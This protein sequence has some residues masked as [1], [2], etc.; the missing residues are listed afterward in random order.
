[1]AAIERELSA[2]SQGISGMK[3]FLD[4]A[5]RKYNSVENTNSRKNIQNRATGR[6]YE[7]SWRDINPLFSNSNYN[8]WNTKG[9]YKLNSISPQQSASET[10]LTSSFWGALSASI[11][12]GNYAK[13]TDKSAISDSLNDLSEF[14]EDNS[15]A[16]PKQEKKPKKQINADEQWYKQTG[17]IAE[18]KAE[19]KVEGSVVNAKASGSTKY[20]QGEV[21]AK[22]VTGEAHASASA[23]LYVYEKGMDGE[24]KKILSPSVMA[25]VGTS[26]AL[27]DVAAN[28]RVGLGEDNNMLGVYGK[29]EVKAASAEAKAKV[30]VNRNEIYAGA[31]AEADLVKVE[32]TAG[33]SVLGTD[34]GGCS[35]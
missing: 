19:K 16:V 35:C 12:P 33:V 34:I 23:G 32:G 20:A 13:Y 14:L 15:I 31:S 1:M 3:T 21:E 30:S 26:V 28:G 9:S 10:A 24:V 4:S 2:Q 17:T 6:G 25:E 27:I 29:G 11:K 7:H 18:A 5:V 22:A 8:P